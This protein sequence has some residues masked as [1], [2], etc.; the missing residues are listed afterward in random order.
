MEGGEYPSKR[1][2]QV[3]RPCGRSME[4]ATQRGW[5]S[6]GKAESRGKGSKRASRWQRRRGS[7]DSVRNFAFC[8]ESHGKSLR[9]AR[10]GSNVNRFTF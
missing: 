4:S 5:V 10:E 1:R 7:V 9:D 3:Q 2:E 8:P 6:G